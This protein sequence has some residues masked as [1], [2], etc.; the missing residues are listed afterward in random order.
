MEGL[1]V[2]NWKYSTV[3]HNDLK[4]LEKD[5]ELMK[6]LLVEGGYTNTVVVDNKEDIAKVVKDFIEI[7]NHPLTERFHFHYSGKEKVFLS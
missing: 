4:Y 5:G 6:N 1:V 7:S 3:D 2:V